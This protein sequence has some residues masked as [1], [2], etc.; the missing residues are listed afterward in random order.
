ML[1]DSY[2]TPSPSVPS[3]RNTVET[4]PDPLA[5]LRE[6]DPGGDEDDAPEHAVRIE[7]ALAQVLAAA[8]AAAHS[9]RLPHHLAQEAERVVREREVVPVAAVVREDRVDVGV[10]MV[11]EADRVRLLADVRV[12]RADELPE[13]EEI[14]E[15]LSKRRMKNIRS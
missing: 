13:R 3:P 8:L 14:E 2:V 4:A 1:S 10:E 15:R 6:R 11:D 12:R 5:L 9:R 7:V